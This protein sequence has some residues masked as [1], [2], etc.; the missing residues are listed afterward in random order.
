MIPCFMVTTRESAK[1]RR[2]PRALVNYHE[3]WQ[4]YT[5]TRVLDVGDGHY[6]ALRPRLIHASAHAMEIIT[7][8]GPLL[9][10]VGQ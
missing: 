7:G 10:L 3:Y 8:S 5:D 4:R 6:P 1:E 9:S 2:K